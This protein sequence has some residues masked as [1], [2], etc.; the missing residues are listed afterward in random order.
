MSLT[1]TYLV[2]LATLLVTGS[3]AVRKFFMTNRSAGYVY[4]SIS[5]LI[6]GVATA[7]FVLLVKIIGG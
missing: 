4:I 3:L 2:V 6:L 5:W 7:V 1:L